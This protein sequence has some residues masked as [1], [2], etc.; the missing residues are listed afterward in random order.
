[1]TEF[2]REP[3]YQDP[4]FQALEDKMLN[5]L[6]GSRKERVSIPGTSFKNG[7]ALS[8]ED[9]QVLEGELLTRLGKLKKTK[10]VIDRIYTREEYKTG[11][12]NVSMAKEI[13]DDNNSGKIFTDYL[14]YEGEF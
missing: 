2:V 3:K 8:P 6:S 7:V 5:F 4:Q 14:L 12:E 13:R 9:G 1:M 10:I 11:I